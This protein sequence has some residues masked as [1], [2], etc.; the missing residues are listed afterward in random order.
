MQ[1]GTHFSQPEYFFV[2][3]QTHISS[4]T[5]AMSTG[6]KEYII[7]ITTT[8]TTTMTAT[9]ITTTNNNTKQPSSFN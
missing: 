5:F 4:G 1:E 7:I 6:S 8:T 2:T 3:P 9:T